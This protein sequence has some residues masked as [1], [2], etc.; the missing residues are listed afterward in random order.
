MRGKDGK[1][2]RINESTEDH[3]RVCGEKMFGKNSNIQDVGSPP[4]MRGKGAGSET[5]WAHVRITPAYAGKRD[6]DLSV[7]LELEDHPR[8]CGEKQRIRVHQGYEVGIT[9]AYAG[10]RLGTRF[11]CSGQ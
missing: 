9:P 3:P 10:K 6:S 8:V 7:L 1:F 11:F 2:I 5:Y 4:R